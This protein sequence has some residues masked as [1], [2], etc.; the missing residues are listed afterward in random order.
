MHIT[1][2][3][4]MT[5]DGRITCGEDPNIHA[6]SSRE[7]WHNFLKLRE[8]CDAIVLDRLSYEVIKPAPDP[9]WLRLVLTNHPGLYSDVAI[10]GQMEFMTG[11]PTEVV[12]TL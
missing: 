11:T 3:V 2:A 12:R 6:W 7:D 9:K 5:A 4:L 1:Y 8:K 10:P